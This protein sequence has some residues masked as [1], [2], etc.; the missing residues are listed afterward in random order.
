MEFWDFIKAHTEEANR[1]LEL[2]CGLTNNTSAFLKMNFS[3]VDGLD[4]D[5]GAKSNRYIHKV[6]IY[7]GK[8]WPVKDMSYDVVVADY[9]L[10]H[11]DRPR[12]TVR[13]AFR[14]LKPGGIFVFRCPNLWHYVTI[15]SRITPH[16]FHRLVANRLRGIDDGGDPY[17]TRYRIN[18]RRSARRILGRCGFEE[19]GI[20]MI[21]KAP[22]YGLGAIPLF[23]L[24][25]LYERMV[26]ATNFLAW[27]RS[28][29]LGAWRKPAHS[30]LNQ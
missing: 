16:W 26:N 7:D 22:W 13:E 1:V 2:G 19:L 24:F 29:I 27:M 15:V 23:F 21:E 9:V 11:L 3:E 17:P 6:I 10:E 25:M 14:A 30:H 12:D 8:T 20:R 5:P 28:N 4:V 18:T